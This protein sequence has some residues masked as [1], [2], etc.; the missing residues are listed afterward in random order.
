MLLN[1]YKSFKIFEDYEYDFILFCFSNSPSVKVKNSLKSISFE[2]L[3]I[4]YEVEVVTIMNVSSRQVVQL[5]AELEQERSKNSTLKTEMAKV[6]VKASI[7][8]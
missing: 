6:G 7:G 1:T 4:I 8:Q 2:L 5:H 3:S